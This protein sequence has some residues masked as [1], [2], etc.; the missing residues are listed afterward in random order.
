[1]PLYINVKSNHTPNIMKNLPE[2]ISFHINKSSSNKSV[3]D[4]SKDLYNNAL[5]S[6]GFKDK[7]KFN[8]DFQK[9][10]SRSKNRKRKIIWF[11][12]P[13]S[14]NISMNINKSLLTILDKHFPK[15]HKL[16]KI[17]NR[18]NVKI[19]YSSMP[20]FASIINSHNEK[21]INNNIPKSSA[22]A[23]NCHSKTSCPLNSACLQSTLIYIFKADM[24][25]IIEN[26]PHYI[27]STENTFK[28]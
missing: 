27:G 8:P 26:H 11:N 20:N 9:N 17:F 25:D 10:I 16:Y 23:C 22:P 14:S 6:S 4:N 2:S 13:Y 18:N 24:S 19:S 3:F 28:D 1:M 21:I 5:S 12:P 15:S 7:I